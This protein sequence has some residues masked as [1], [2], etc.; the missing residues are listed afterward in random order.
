MGKAY[1]VEITGIVSSGDTSFYSAGETLFTPL[2]NF[3]QEGSLYVEEEIFPSNYEST[4]RNYLDVG[5]IAGNIATT[6]PTPGDIRFTSNTALNEY[7]DGNFSQQAAIDV[8][9]QS[10]DPITGELVLEITTTTQSAYVNHLNT[11]NTSNNIT[12]FEKQIVAG[13]LRFSFSDDYE[14]IS[15]S[16]SFIGSGSISP[17][18]FGYAAEFEGVLVDEYIGLAENNNFIF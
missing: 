8:T 18:T 5:L 14:Y 16:I 2:R 3:I 11:F 9:E 10:I 7:F 6:T 17:S 4:D 15:G 13:E 1:N 12:L